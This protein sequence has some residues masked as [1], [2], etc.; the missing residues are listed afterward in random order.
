MKFNTLLKQSIL[1]VWQYVQVYSEHA[2]LLYQIQE[3]QIFLVISLVQLSRGMIQ[4][5]EISHFNA[6]LSM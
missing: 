1:D 6:L 3:L 2:S 5:S 4:I